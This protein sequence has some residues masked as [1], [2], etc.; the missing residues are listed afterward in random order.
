MFWGTGSIGKALPMNSKPPFP[1]CKV[2]SQE[3][4]TQTSSSLGL[5][6]FAF[7]RA[8]QKNKDMAENHTKSLV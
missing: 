5:L 4:Q 7:Q 6:A 8:Q 3:I 1:S 2:N